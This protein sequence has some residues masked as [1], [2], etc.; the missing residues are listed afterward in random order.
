M[1]NMLVSF[2]GDIVNMN[3][4]KIVCLLLAFLLIL[5]CASC[6]KEQTDKGE[7]T[8]ETESE[9]EVEIVDATDIL[10]KVWSEYSNPFDI[11]GGHFESYVLGAPAKYDLSK[12]EDLEKTFCIP[13][14]YV[15]EITDVATMVDLYNAARFTASAVHVTNTE[16]I[17]MFIDAVKTQV[18]SNA[19]HGETPESL[20]IVEL[21]EG[22]VVVVYGREN[23]V[24]EFKT[25]LLD[26]YAKKANVVVE[27][28]GLYETLGGK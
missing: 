15:L 1:I 18:L 24:D 20:V 21:E 2:L 23:L 16:N 4:K 17:Q 22:Y 8:Q 27:E 28:N 14:S 9:V 26:V 25:I 11:M 5:T 19:W 7:N 10:L 12:A 6:G 13:S 3:K